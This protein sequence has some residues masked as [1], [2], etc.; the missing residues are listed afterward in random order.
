MDLKI[1]E[2]SLKKHPNRFELTMMAVARA[3][4][5]SAGEKPLIQIDKDEKPV[6]VALKELAAGLL[7]PATMEEMERIREE[8]RIGREKARREAMEEAEAEGEGG[9]NSPH[10]ASADGSQ[11]T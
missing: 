5:L 2:N 6:I 8:A 10:T 1:L 7:V 9:M 3:R 4:E 11:A